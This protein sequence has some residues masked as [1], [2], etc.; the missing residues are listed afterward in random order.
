MDKKELPIWIKAVG[1]TGMMVD[2][3]LVWV[4]LIHLLDRYCEVF[5]K[6]FLYTLCGLL[7]LAG[8]IYGAWLIIWR[9]RK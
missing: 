8:L 7:M 1:F 9:I 2:A 3:F 6:V 4:L 5:L